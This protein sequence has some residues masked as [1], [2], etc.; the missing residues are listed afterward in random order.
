VLNWRVSLSVLGCLLVGSCRLLLA[1]EFPGEGVIGETQPRPAL[2]NP[3]GDVVGR[4]IMIDVYYRGD[5]PGDAAWL[6]RARDYAAARPGLQV[7]G[8]DVA[9]DPALAEHLQSIRTTLKLPATAVPLVYGFNRAIHEVKDT[10]DFERQVTALLKIEMYS[11]PNC[12]HCDQAERYFQSTLQQYPAL[13]FV[14]RNVLADRQAEADL[15]ALL[16]RRNT[17]TSTVPVLHVANQ[18]LI[19]FDQAQRSGDKIDEVLRRWSTEVR[20]SKKVEL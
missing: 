16:K 19:G 15:Q 3:D 5:V 13:T 8:R 17:S 6:E 12:P 11:K 10:A 14:K 18:L 9:K 7:N 20:S 4:V 2:V 1:N